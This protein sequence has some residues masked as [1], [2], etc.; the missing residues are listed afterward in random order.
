MT[1][2]RITDRLRETLG[3][4][5]DI[6]SQMRWLELSHATDPR[7]SDTAAYK[8]LT[9]QLTTALSEL[10]N[11]IHEPPPPPDGPMDLAN[12]AFP[13]AIEDAIT[14]PVL[15]VVGRPPDAPPPSRTARQAI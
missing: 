7:K 9:D 12:T 15:H 10:L 13:M 1:G 14:A 3:D 2:I 6:H 11:E 4:I 8:T 5:A